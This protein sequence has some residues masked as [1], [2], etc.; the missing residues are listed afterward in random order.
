MALRILVASLAVVLCTSTASAQGYKPKKPRRQ[1]I[2]ISTEWLNTQP[3]HF[4]EH[5][6]QDLV[7]R[8]VAAAQFQNYDYHTRDEQILIDVLEFKRKGRGAGVTLYPFGLSVGPA[9]ALRASVEDLPI[10]RIAFAGAG[11][12]PDYSLSGARAY[13]F[14]AALYVADHSRGWGLGSHA[15]VGGGFGRIRSDAADGTRIFAEGGGGLTSG[16]IGVD[17]SL[18]FGWNRLPTPVEHRFF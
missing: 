3:L 8:D 12:P 5:P 2:T 7:G 16:P 15:F 14:G 4:L 18:K 9:L 1:F 13:D 6:L 10:I 17:L 11:A